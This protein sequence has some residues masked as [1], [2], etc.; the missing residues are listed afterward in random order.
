MRLRL[1]DRINNFGNGL[2]QLIQRLLAMRSGAMV[3][4]LEVTGLDM[5]YSQARRLSDIEATARNLIALLTG[6]AED[7][8]APTVR[9]EHGEPQ[10]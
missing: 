6:V 1:I 2:A 5:G 7:S 8:F 4:A 9:V 10:R 3:G